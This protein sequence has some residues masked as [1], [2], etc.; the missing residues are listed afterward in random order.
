METALP[1]ILI[2]LVALGVMGGAIYI[3]RIAD[4]WFFLDRGK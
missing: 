2:S 3:W 4:A 1:Y